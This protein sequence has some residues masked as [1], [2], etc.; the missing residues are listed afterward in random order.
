MKHHIFPNFLTNE[1]EYHICESYW[2]TKIRYLL[3]EHGLAEPVPYLNT[4]FANGKAQLNGNPIA[5][6]YI[7]HKDKA[8]RI[9]QEEPETEGLEISAWIN[10]LETENLTATE[11]VITLELTPEAER[12]TFDLISKWLIQNYSPAVMTKYID[13][14][15]ESTNPTPQP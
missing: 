12:I 9:I 10:K 13:Y 4:T 2:D 3:E 8:I 11:L 1:Q 14:I 5:N 15:Y 6:Y 7:K